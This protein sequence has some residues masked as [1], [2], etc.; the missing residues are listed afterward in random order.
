MDGGSFEEHL[1]QDLRDVADA[2]V[3]GRDVP[4]GHLLERVQRRLQ[5]SP[6]G[7]RRWLGAPS[8][9]R[10]A[11]VVLA[12]IFGL[13]VSGALATVLSTAGL[14]TTSLTNL[15]VTQVLKSVTSPVSYGSNSLSAADEV[16]CTEGTKANF[17]WHYSGQNS[18]GT[19]TSGSWSGTQGATCPDDDLSM[20]PQ[21]ME[22][23]LK[24]APGTTLK[25]GY[26]LTV[27]GL[28]SAVNITVT[29]PKVTFANVHCASGATPTQS[30]FTVT[31][32]NAT[33]HVTTTAWYPSGDQSS[34][35]VY[36]GSIPVPNLCPGGT[37]HRV[38]LDKGGTFTA[39][40]S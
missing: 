38:R 29:N 1:P 22:G 37:D 36:Q 9:R 34:P 40:V 17:R 19:F 20:G 7:R 10:T 27:P 18:N 11:A 8:P 23:D 16:Y 3:A 2:L 30:S 26:D 28:S 5:A 33:Y 39:S 31:M 4:D 12:V 32:P 35:L 24:V 21:A 14:G 6:R 13:N 15:N 25:V